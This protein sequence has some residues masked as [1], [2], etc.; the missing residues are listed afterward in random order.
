MIAMHSST[1]N[2]SFRDLFQS[3]IDRPDPNGLLA[4]MVQQLQEAEEAGDR[5]WVIGHIPLG[6]EDT[7]EDQVVYYARY[8]PW[9]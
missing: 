6:K 7:A 4:F 5:V 2:L 3:A 1:H 9:H 8:L